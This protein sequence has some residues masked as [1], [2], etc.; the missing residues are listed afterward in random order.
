M[1]AATTESVQCFG[2]EKMVVAVTQCERGRGLSEING[3]P[4]ELVQPKILLTR[5]LN[6]FYSSTATALPELTCASA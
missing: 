3:V 2:R 6:Q 4:I 1:A 5:L